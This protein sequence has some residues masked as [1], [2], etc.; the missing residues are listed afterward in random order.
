MLC[1]PQDAGKWLDRAGGRVIEGVRHVD[2][3]RGQRAL[4]KA[5][6][7]D[8]LLGK[9]L[10]RRLVACEAPGARAA[11]RVMHE[12]DAA[13]VACSGDDLVPEYAAREGRQQLFEVRAAHAAGEDADQFAAAAFRLDN[14]G[15]LKPTSF[16]DDDRAHGRIVRMSTPAAPNPMAVKLHR[17]KY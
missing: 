4:G 6:R 13:V 12:R 16:T 2:T 5:A 17:F 9:T 15:K 1:R 8:R 3:V 14:V 10:A 11:R 7:H